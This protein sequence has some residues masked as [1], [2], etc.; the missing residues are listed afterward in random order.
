MKRLSLLTVTAL[1]LTGCAPA[2]DGERV[3]HEA[4]YEAVHEVMSIPNEMDLS[5]S[6]QEVSNALATNQAMVQLVHDTH[7]ELTDAAEKYGTPYEFERDVLVCEQ[8]SEE[9]LSDCINESIS[10]YGLLED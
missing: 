8:L 3:A 9:G 5:R 1:L 4:S 6:V 10:N 2:I 7:K